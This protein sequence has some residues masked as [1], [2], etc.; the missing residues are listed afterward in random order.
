MDH[1]KLKND[2]VVLPN[3]LRKVV[4]AV[5]DKY[6]ARTKKGFVV[7][8][9]LRTPASQAAAMYAKLA[10]GDTLAIYKDQ[11]SAGE[12]GDAFRAGRASGLLREAIIASLVKVIRRQVTEGRFLS[13]HLTGRAADVRSVDMTPGEQ[14]AFK[15]AVIQVV[16]TPPI[17]EDKP[18]HFHFQMKRAPA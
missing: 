5:A 16:G 13:L 12:V 3:D 14:D 1:F 2:T 15:Q 18:P 10:K 6:F 7:T 17:F 9:G 11:R 4:G 8:S